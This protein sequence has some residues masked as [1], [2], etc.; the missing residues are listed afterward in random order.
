M[1]HHNTTA[2]QQLQRQ[3]PNN[4]AQTPPASH[5]RVSRR[6][7]NRARS[8]AVLVLLLV[9]SILPVPASRTG[10]SKYCHA[11]QGFDGRGPLPAFDGTALVCSHGTNHSSEAQRFWREWDYGL[12]HSYRSDL[13]PFCGGGHDSSIYCGRG[14]RV[15]KRQSVRLATPG[16]TSKTF[17]SE[18]AGL[19][20]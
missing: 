16:F 13:L 19:Q 11:S 17:F 2:F 7:G 10:R 9:S 12:L 15:D 14:T 18:V 20:E 1:H 6:R 4:A 8:A 5:G 3:C